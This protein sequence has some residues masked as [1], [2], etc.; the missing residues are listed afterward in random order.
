MTT[1]SYPD[2]RVARVQTLKSD[3]LA[4]HSGSG[5][6][7]VWTNYLPSLGL[8]FNIGKMG[9]IIGTFIEGLM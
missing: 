3:C 1:Q 7:L 6:L 4:S 2:S 5:H 9:M 8:G